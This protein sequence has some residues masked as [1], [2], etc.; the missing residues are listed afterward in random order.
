[1][2]KGHEV[3]GQLSLTTEVE[4]F[5]GISGRHQRPRSGREH[6]EAGR[7]VRRRLSRWAGRGSRSFEA[8]VPAECGGRVDRNPHADRGFGREGALARSAFRAE[9]DRPRRQFLRHLR[10]LLLPREEDHGGGRRRFRDGRSELPDALRPRG[11]AGA[12]P[13][14]VPRFEDHAGARA[15]QSEDRIHHE[16]RGRGGVRCEAEHRHRACGCAIW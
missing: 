14:C 11:G 10:R 5:P 9:A 15:G 3:G 7:A 1:M 6:E 4:N 13:R 8:A 2:I 16:Y 12:S